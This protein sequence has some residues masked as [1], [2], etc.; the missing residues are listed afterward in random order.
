M[1]EICEALGK[2]VTRGYRGRAGG[3]NVWLGGLEGGKKERTFSRVE[4]ERT[5]RR[6]RR[7][8]RGGKEGRERVGNE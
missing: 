8:R 6:G 3:G 1:R 2:R 7:G 5:G 4:R